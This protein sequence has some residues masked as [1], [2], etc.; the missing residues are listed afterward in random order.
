[1]LLVRHEKADRTYWL[2]PG[3]GVEDGESLKQ[4]ARRELLEETG[5][6]VE[7]NQFLSVVETIAPDKSRHVLNFIF[8]ATVVG[9]NLQLG[10]ETDE[11][12]LAEVKWT[13][14]SELGQLTLHPPIG[15]LLQNL[16]TGARDTSV[17]TPTFVEGLWTD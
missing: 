3:G 12:R 15:S 6:Q 1:M 2:L 17:S 14:I 4:A 9:G 16:A 10:I 5:L 11:Q 8:S 13:P 7:I